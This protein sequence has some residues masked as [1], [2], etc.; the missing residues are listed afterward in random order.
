MTEYN[1]ARDNAIAS[2]GKIIRHQNAFVTADQNM[3]SQLV[4]YWI[5]LLPITHDVEEG[6]A[7]YEF[8]CDFLLGKPEF[9]FSGDPATTAVQLAKIFGEAF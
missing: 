2:L 7:Q 6:Q 1:H 8:L 9:I 5:G 3:A 4:A